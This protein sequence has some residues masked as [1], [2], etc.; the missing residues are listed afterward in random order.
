MGYLAVWKV[1]E[2]MAADLKKRRV[3]VPAKVVCDLKN[4]RTIITILRVDSDRGENVQKV[5][6]YLATLE[7]YLVTEGQRRFGKAYVDEWLERKNKASRETVDGEEEESRFITGLPRGQKWI[8][9][10][11]SKEMPAQELEVLA[12]ESHLSH[13]AQ[14]EGGFVVFG[15]ELN[16]KDFVRKIAAGYK[17]K[18]AKT[19]TKST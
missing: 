2:E 11:T 12:E 9:L 4:A 13:E 10:I 3:T 16:L 5:E 14:T 6:E 8:R 18:T 7:S 19:A 17:P 15:P 1:L